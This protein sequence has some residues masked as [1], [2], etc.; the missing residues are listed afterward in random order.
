MAPHYEAF[1]G[2][3]VVMRYGEWLAGLLDLAAQRGVRGGRALDVGCGTGR[4]LAALLTAG[5]EASGVDP[6]RGMMDIAR[7]RLGD[8]VELQV[9]GLPDVPDGP[10]VDLVTAFNDI[11]NCVG[12]RDLDAAIAG[13][14]SRL[15]PGGILLF[16]ANTPLTFSTFFGKTFCRSSPDL[17][18]VWESLEPGDDGGHRADLHAFEADPD[19][20]GCWRRSISHHVQHHHPHARV[21]AALAAAGLELLLVQGQQDNGPRDPFCDESIH[22]KRIYV[23][24]RP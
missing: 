22:T 19:E 2:D 6:S 4:S 1:V 7:A 21:T 12:P 5:F 3:A 20:P 13:L 9:G 18:L 23:A 8:D 16:D 10:P 11:I 15:V 17:F 24:R 14:A